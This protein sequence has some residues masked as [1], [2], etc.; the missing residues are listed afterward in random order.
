[1]AI[2]NVENGMSWGSYG[3]GSDTRAR[4]QKKPLGKPTF[5]NDKN[6]PKTKSTFLCHN[7][8]EIFY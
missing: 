2:Q 4:T 1:M 6:P 8:E 7:N 5:K 3:Q